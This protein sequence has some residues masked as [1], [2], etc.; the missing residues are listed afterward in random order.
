MHYNVETTGQ[1]LVNNYLAEIKD[2]VIL[3]TGVSLGGLGAH[4][5]A[6]VAVGNPAL[7]ILAGRNLQKCHATADAVSSTF[8]SI[9]TKLLELDLGSFQT[10]RKAAEEVLSWDDVPHI[11]IL[12]NN[13]G[14]MAVPFSLSPDGHESQFASNHLGHFLFTNLIMPKMMNSDAPRVISVS[15]AACRFSHIRFPDI[16][17]HVR[18]FRCP[19]CTCANM[20]YVR[21]ATNTKNGLRTGNLKRPICFSQCRSPRS[22]A[23][24][25]WHLAF[26]QALS[27]PTYPAI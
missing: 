24:V 22:S 26:I 18:T 8:P 13:A 11:D 15:S 12:V 2:K 1:E 3:T 23:S 14:I 16:N 5:L 4:F 7:L 9:R 6:A 19:Y 25:F 17:F 21:T 27:R 20:M 10:V